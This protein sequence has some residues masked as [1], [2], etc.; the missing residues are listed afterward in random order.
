MIHKIVMSILLTLALPTTGYGL[1]IQEVTSP[2]GIKAWLVEDHSIPFT[3]LEIEFNGGAALEELDNFGAAYFLVGMF[4]E[5]AGD[6]DAAAFQRRQQELAADYSFNAYQESLTV[7]VK[8]LTENKDESINLL[9]LA[10]ERPRFDQDRMELVR[11]QILAVLARRQNDLDDIAS[12]R[13]NELSYGNHPFGRPLEGTI[14]T[15]QSLTRED[16]EE[17]R[18]QALTRGGIIVAAAGDITAAELGKLLDNL[19]AGLP[20]TTPEPVVEPDYLLDGGITVIEYPS[21]QS[22][23]FFKH[24]GILRDDPDFL[25]AYVMNEIL[26]SGSYS[27]RLK[28][29]VREKRGLTY[30]IASY[31]GAYSNS[32]FLSGRFATDNNS[33]VEAIE[34]VKSEWQR[35]AEE[36]VTETELNQVKTYLIGAYPLRF[37]G[38]SR[39]A[40]ILA[41]MQSDR[42]PVSYVR[43]RNSYVDALTVE[44]INRVATR[45]L[46]PDELHFVVV[47]QPKGL[48]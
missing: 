37:D 18:Q 31:I 48:N 36:G 35:L 39:I 45:L 7:S 34:I 10:L 29:E 26:G 20:I 44:D 3:A 23:V 24:K 33:V 46:H 19:F 1:E 22:T 11:N 38:N 16:L 28:E 41:G 2:D 4:E 42:L 5:G 43:N 12:D 27:S 15:V 6:L 8:F 30:G 17:F 25:T 9:R 47:G 32:G 21:P 40:S 14:E 13:I